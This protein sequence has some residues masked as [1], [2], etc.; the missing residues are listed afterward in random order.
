MN[1]TPFPKI[2]RL[3]RDVVVTEKIDGTNG[4]ILIAPFMPAE[5]DVDMPLAAVGAY[6]IYAGSRNR[7]VYPHQDNYGFAAWV[8]EN[9]QAL[10]ESLGEGHHYGEWWGRGIQRNYSQP[11]RYFSLFNV[12]RWGMHFDHQGR[13]GPCRVV[14]TLYHGLLDD[15]LCMNGLRSALRQLQDKGSVAAPGFMNPEGV[16]IYHT[17]AGQMFKKTFEKDDSGKDK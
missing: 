2:P 10:V 5:T 7:W 14:P 11:E 3:S 13:V 12:K 8:L 16:I 1:F 9:A 4:S 17:A 6:M 15:N